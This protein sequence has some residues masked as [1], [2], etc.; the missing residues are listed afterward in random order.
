MS[1]D[2]LVDPAQ[3]RRELEQANQVQQTQSDQL[4]SELAA[5]QSRIPEKYRGKSVEELAKIAEDIE[6]EKSRLGNELGQ[7]RKQLLERQVETKPK[8]P[9]K[10]VTA[11]EVLTNPNDAIETVVSQS[12]T[13]NKV[14]ESVA[15]LDELERGFQHQAFE[16]AH[17]T[18]MSD[19]KD[20]AFL[21]WVAKSPVRQGLANR[22][23]GFDFQAADQLWSLWEEQQE[24][25]R[26][27]AE[28]KETAK[29]QNREQKLKA[30]M[31]ESG[32]G[33]T[34]ETAKKFSRFEIQNLKTRAKQGDRAAEL[35]VSD[36]NWQRE[37]NQA[38]ADGRVK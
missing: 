3:R 14:K 31:V 37:V 20:Q 13:I 7:T 11:D 38:Y 15:R 32:T 27:V 29:L 5:V 25:V 35:I 33:G 9:P 8:E 6:R 26:Q 34:T 23:D 21:D 17:P 28:S 12:P 1:L 18:Y 2:I 4:D 30:G 10:Q 16:K 36:P 22:A 19:L 24:L